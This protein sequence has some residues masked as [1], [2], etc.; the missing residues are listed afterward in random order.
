MRSFVLAA[1]ILASTALVARAED[2]QPPLI[3]HT[4]VAKAMK[5]DSVTISAQ[6]EDESEIFAPTLYFR[7]PGA[8]GYSSVAMTRKGDAFVANV[9]A[10]ADIEYWIEAYD[11]FGNGPTRE[12]SPDR[13]HRVGVAEK[14]AAPKVA[15]ADPVAPPMDPPPPAPA[16]VQQFD[17]TAA[18][19]ALPPPMVDLEPLEPA[20]L[21]DDLVEPS[22][23]YKQ[24]WFL[25][26]VGVVAAAAVVGIV[27][28]SQ[29][30]PIN[31]NTFG[32]TTSRP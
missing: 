32:V 19:D 5:G 16:D 14:A 15:K 23:V 21:P 27:Y 22:P 8:R 30:D 11:E 26:T 6:M 12:G 9:Q 25:G 17:A 3:N 24:G 29:P 4:P 13:P 18:V 20:P 2:T 28:V 10:T 1:F 31:R 7:Y